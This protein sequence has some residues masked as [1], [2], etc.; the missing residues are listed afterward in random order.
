MKA[1]WSSRT[2]M[3]PL[4]SMSLT[5]RQERLSKKSRLEKQ[6]SISITSQMTWKMVRKTCLV[7]FLEFRPRVCIRLIQ[8][9]ELTAWSTLRFIKA[10]SS[11]TLFALHLT[12][13][14][15]LA[16]LMVTLECTSRWVRM[17]SLSCLDLVSLSSPSISA[18]MR[19][20]CLLPARHSSWSFQPLIKM[21]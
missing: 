11:S 10:M 7:L 14:L 21:E 12:M 6:G 3:T 5:L 13:A 1:N 4:S 8:G 2:R 20:G 17:L 19:N 18:R 16:V 15:L 9:L